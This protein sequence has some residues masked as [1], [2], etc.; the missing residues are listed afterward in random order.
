MYDASFVN[1]TVIYSDYLQEYLPHD[2][3]SANGLPLQRESELLLRALTEF[4]LDQ[5]CYK[6]LN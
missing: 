2:S 6:L 4:W 3:G 1:T 5:V